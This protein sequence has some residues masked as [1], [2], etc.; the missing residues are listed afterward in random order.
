MPQMMP[1][2]WISLMFFFIFCFIFI[3]YMNYFNFM[4]MNKFSFK[5]IN[6]HYNWKW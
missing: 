1:L 4:Y 5:K 2:N 3:N 6:N